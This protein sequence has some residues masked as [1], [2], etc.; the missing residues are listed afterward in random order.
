MDAGPRR[1]VRPRPRLKRDRKLV[2]R[3]GAPRVEHGPLRGPDVIRKRR[4]HP[5]RHPH[6]GVPALCVE[7]RRE[8][9]QGS[10]L[11]HLPRRVERKVGLLIDERANRRDAPFGRLHVAQVGPAWAGGVGVAPHRRRPRER[12]RT[13]VIGGRGAPEAPPD[14]GP[15][16]WSAAGSRRKRSIGRRSE[17]RTRR[18]PPTA[19]PTRAPSSCSRAAN[20]RG[21]EVRW[22]RAA[23]S[24]G[25]K[26][27][28]NVWHEP[29]GL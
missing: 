28:S 13:A 23:A 14:V 4:P 18:S 3:L 1:R 26:E 7:R 6:R 10:G 29:L 25:A 19:R 12:V 24:Y 16:V 5:H 17:R 2:S 21:A 22:R 8:R 27:A 15:M 11:A 20:T 9:R